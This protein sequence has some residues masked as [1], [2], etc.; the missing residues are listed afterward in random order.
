M[1]AILIAGPTASGK[2]R[3]AIAKARETGGVIVNADSMQVY[4][5]L[6]IL[7]ARPPR[8]D[9]AS[10]PHRLYGHVPPQT[11]YSVGQWLADVARAL[12][13]VRSAGRVPIVV[14]GTGLYFKA[15]TEGLTTIPPIPAAYRARLRAETADLPAEALHRKLAGIDAEDAAAIRPG[16]RAR[17]LR[18]LEVFETTGRS[19][20]SW[21]ASD[22][23]VALVDPGRA[24][25]MV[26]DPD[27]RALH[28]RIS[29][30]A[31]N[32]IRNGAAD[33]ARALS[34]SGST[35]TRRR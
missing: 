19:L 1:D 25:A 27:R 34:P 33:E 18:A 16:D 2:S 24:D 23:P 15:L 26:V 5:G 3:L 20:R 31:E 28:A 13:E 9:E 17:I 12:A 29:E 8:E 10:A 22:R 30:R 6:R 11:R 14:G 7:S 21:H 35:R 32:M 4:A